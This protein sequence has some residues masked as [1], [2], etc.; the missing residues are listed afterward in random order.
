MQPTSGLKGQVCRLAYE[1]AATWYQ[2]TLIQVTRVNCRNGFAIDGMVALYTSPGILLCIIIDTV[3]LP[4][5][6]GSS[7]DL[8]RS[9]R[10][11]IGDVQAPAT[12]THAYQLIIDT[13]DNTLFCS[14]ICS[15]HILRHAMRANRPNGTEMFSSTAELFR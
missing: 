15:A 8:V 5:L 12:A 11:H 14:R 4:L 7:P 10:L 1:L 13:G 3:E 9:V 6:S 2:P